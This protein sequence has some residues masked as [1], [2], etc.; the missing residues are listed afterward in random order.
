[1]AKKLKP[2]INTT[3]GGLIDKTSY[4][5]ILIYIISVIILFALIYIMLDKFFHGHGTNKVNANILDYLYFSVVTFAT[6]GYGDIV[7][8]GLSKLLVI[9]EVLSGMFLAAIFIGKI[10]SERQ[11]T[12]LTLIYSSINHQRIL[13]LIVDINLIES[14]MNTLYAAHDNQNLLAK[15]K[16][17]YDLVSI[18]RK[19]LTVQSLEGEL[20]SF[21]NSSTLRRLYIALAKLQKSISIINKTFGIPE[22]IITIQKRTITSI[23]EIGKNMKQFHTDE[24]KTISNLNELVL[25]TER[26]AK[27][28]GI[29][30]TYRTEV[31]KELLENIN[32]Y[33]NRFPDLLANYDK[34]TEKTGITKKLLVRCIEKIN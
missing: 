19:Y 15:S 23:G 24:E 32:S 16:D 12:K 27:M 13:E 2:K 33:K 18:I 5:Q 14:E 34:I 6:L 10:S 31:T 22:N 20:A 1:M 30:G 28:E 29:K 7:P 26:S 8:V 9:I 25:E 11:S 17:I 4:R 21:G 3:F